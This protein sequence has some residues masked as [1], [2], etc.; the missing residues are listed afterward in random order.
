M[1]QN[2]KQILKDYYKNE[3]IEQS[4]ITKIASF[5]KNYLKDQ[6]NQDCDENPDDFLKEFVSHF[7]LFGLTEAFKKFKENQELQDHEERAVITFANT[8]TTSTLNEAVIRSKCQDK[9]LQK[10]C[11][12]PSEIVADSSE[13]SYKKAISEAEYHTLI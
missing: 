11:E 1:K 13:D 3:N 6:N 7:P 9:E 8:F 12:Q 2:I 5:Y 4:K 10:S